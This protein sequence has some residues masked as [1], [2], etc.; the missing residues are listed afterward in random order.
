[1]GVEVSVFVYYGARRQYSID[2]IPVAHLP[3]DEIFKKIVSAQPDACAVHFPVREFCEEYS[4]VQPD[5]PFGLW[6][7]GVETL[8]WKRRLFNY[9]VGLPFLRYIFDNTRQLWRLRCFLRSMSDNSNVRKIYVSEWMHR[10]AS[11]DLHLR[12]ENFEVIPNPIDTEL[13]QHIP[14]DPQAR[15]HVLLLRSFTS[16]KYANDLAVGAIL[17]LAR[18]D[19]SLFAEMKFSIYGEGPLFKPLTQQL[20]HLSNVF[21]SERYFPRQ[22]I[23]KLHRDHGVFLVPTRQDAQGVSMCEAMSSG[24]VPVTSRN[25]AIPE[26]VENRKEGLL[27]GG[28][29][30][31]AEGLRELASDPTLFLK[32]SHAAAAR[33]RHQCSGPQV[34]LRELGV[35]GL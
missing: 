19:P 24:L 9:K 12:I 8:S 10:I 16:Q 3:I 22:E 34:A 31:L 13:F 14:K 23:P 28:T 35:L 7:H 20:A 17:E 11:R 15:L 21:C 26:F 1:M 18:V 4:R 2:G 25:T 33:M 29:T 32:M 27:T 30:E 6:F 5:M